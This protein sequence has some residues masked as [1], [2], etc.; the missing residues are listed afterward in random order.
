[1]SVKPVDEANRLKDEELTVFTD[2]LLEGGADVEETSRPPLADVVESLAR[3]LS[4]QPPPDDLQRR[5]QKRI[6]AEWA[7]QRPA[8][9]WHFPRL[10]GRPAQRLAW[11]VAIALVLVAMATVLLIPA[12]L[13]G[14]NA[15]TAG[16]TV[17][18]VWV[19][20]LVLI[21][22]VIIAAWFVARR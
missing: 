3:T 10:F 13:E 22:V 7:R 18:A 5:L 15:T 20:A 8:R 19:I 11:A 1:M 4:P 9:R 17:S 12:S 14:L 2:A 21:S 16:E 6:R